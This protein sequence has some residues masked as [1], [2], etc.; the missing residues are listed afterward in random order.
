MP[1]KTDKNKK[2]HID[3]NS[4]YVK[5]KPIPVFFNSIQKEYDIYRYCD[6]IIQDCSAVVISY[7][8]KTLFMILVTVF[9]L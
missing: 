3:C 2:Y 4:V 8:L 7:P 5:G 1:R 6:V 9:Q